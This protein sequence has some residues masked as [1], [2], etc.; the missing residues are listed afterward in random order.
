[1]PDKISLTEEEVEQMVAIF[2]AIKRVHAAIGVLEERKMRNQGRLLEL[3]KAEDEWEKTI[4]SKYHIPSGIEWRVDPQERA[5]I[6]P[7]TKEESPVEEP[8]SEPE[9]QS[10]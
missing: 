4:E 1:M 5:V 3:R 7:E 6:L 2:T 8:P 10:D 9:T